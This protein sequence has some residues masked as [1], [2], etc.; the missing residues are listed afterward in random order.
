MGAPLIFDTTL[1]DGEQMPSVVLSH[2]EAVYFSQSA[3]SLR[4]Y[5]GAIPL[6]CVYKINY[7]T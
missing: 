2:F 1:R 4:N 6:V 5:G 7:E 3:E